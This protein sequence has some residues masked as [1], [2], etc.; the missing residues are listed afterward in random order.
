MAAAC[1]KPP[2][3]IGGLAWAIDRTLADAQRLPAVY[4][5]MSLPLAAGAAA[6]LVI[7]WARPAPWLFALLLVVLLSVLWLFAVTRFLRAHAW[8]DQARAD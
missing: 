4:R 5:P 1:C 8:E 6:T 7:G 3:C 2:P